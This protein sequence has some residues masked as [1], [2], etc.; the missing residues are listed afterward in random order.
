[1]ATKLRENI[2]NNKMVA[3]LQQQ[4]AAKDVR[5][6]LTNHHGRRE[7]LRTRPTSSRSHWCPSRPTWL[8]TL[9]LTFS[10]ISCT[11]ICLMHAVTTRVRLPAVSTLGHPFNVV[12]SGER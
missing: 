7:A 5:L 3:Q 11:L 10:R 2:Q 1:M 12:G 6:C 4:N 9:S 8:P